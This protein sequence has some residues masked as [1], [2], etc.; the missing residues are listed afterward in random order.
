MYLPEFLVSQ[1][2]HCGC[3]S[4]LLLCVTENR[5]VV[6]VGGE[7][8]VRDGVTTFS[9]MPRPEGQETPIS[10]TSLKIER[11]RKLEAQETGM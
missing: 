3:V 8:E 9:T 2:W 6:V 5:H 7:Q 1:R 11:N 4:Y 10:P